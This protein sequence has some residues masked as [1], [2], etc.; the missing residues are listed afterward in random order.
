MAENQLAQGRGLSK[1]EAAIPLVPTGANLVGGNSFVSTSAASSSLQSAKLNQST[2][3]DSGLPPA[4]G[5]QSALL[6]LPK[7]TVDGFARVD[8]LARSYADLGKADQA[9][10]LY[11]QALV[12]LR[13]SNPPRNKDIASAS[14]ALG[15]LYAKR[16]KYSQASG[17]FKTALNLLEGMSGPQSSTLIPIL[18]SYADSLEKCNNLA[19]AAK[20]RSRANLIKGAA[21]ACKPSDPAKDF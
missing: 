16:G 2:A 10:A 13:A 3:K 14:M 8:A 19:E 15:T 4:T 17:L 1:A 21:T 20:I 9:E 12:A 7:I 11:A 5:S 6:P 18:D